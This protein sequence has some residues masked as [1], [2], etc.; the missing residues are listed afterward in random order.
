MDEKGEDE[1]VVVNAAQISGLDE[2]TLACTP[3]PVIASSAMRRRGFIQPRSKPQPKD[4][5]QDSDLVEPESCGADSN[6]ESLGLIPSH[7]LLD[8]NGS[9]LPLSSLTSSL[10]GHAASHID[11]G[12]RSAGRSCENGA[13][14]GSSIGDSSKLV[15]V[16]KSS[17]VK[18]CE[19]RLV[20]QTLFRSLSP[21]PA[22]IEEEPQEE[23]A[24]LSLQGNS[25]KGVLSRVTHTTDGIKSLTATTKEDEEADH[26]VHQVALEAEDLEELEEVCFDLDGSSSDEEPV[27]N[28]DVQ[29]HERSPSDQYF[30]P[31]G[32]LPP[33]DRLPPDGHFPPEDRFPSILYKPSKNLSYQLQADLEAAENRSASDLMDSSS[34]Y[35]QSLVFGPSLQF[36]NQHSKGLGLNPFDAQSAS[37]ADCAF[38]DEEFNT[39]MDD[40]GAKAFLDQDEQAFNKENFLNNQELSLTSARETDDTFNNMTI[41]TYMKACSEPLGLLGQESQRPD[42]GL[43]IQ[44]PPRYR[45]AAPI[46]E[47]D[48]VDGSSI[49]TSVRLSPVG[50]T[51]SNINSPTNK[52]T[53]NWS[54]PL[55]T[56]SPSVGNEYS[57]AEKLDLTA[58]NKILSHQTI[59]GQ[60]YCY[61]PDCQTNN[62]IHSLQTPP[63]KGDNT[64]SYS[65]K[66]DFQANTRT[67]SHQTGASLSDSGHSHSGKLDFQASTRT[68]P[69]QTGASLGDSGHSHSRKLDFQAST[70]TNPHQTGAS[71]GDSG[72]SYSDKQDFQAISRSHSHQTTTAI[73]E[74]GYSNDEKLKSQ[75]MNRTQSCQAETAADDSNKTLVASS[76][77][78]L[79]NMELTFS[80]LQELLERSDLS[81]S[82]MGGPDQDHGEFILAFLRQRAEEK[83]RELASSKTDSKSVLRNEKFDEGAGGDASADRS[84]Y[85]RRF[86]S[87]SIPSKLPTPSYSEKV[88]IK[89][90]DLSLLPRR[91][92]ETVQ[93]TGS[94]AVGEEAVKISHNVSSFLRDQHK[95]DEDRTLGLNDLTLSDSSVFKVPLSIASKSVRN[96]GKPSL[97]RSKIPRQV[98][99]TS[100]VVSSD[101][102]SLTPVEKSSSSSKGPTLLEKSGSLL[103]SVLS[104]TEQPAPT[105]SMNLVTNVQR[106]AHPVPDILFSAPSPSSY[107]KPPTMER[108]L[109]SESG[110]SNYKQPQ[111][112]NSSLP[113]LSIVSSHYEAQAQTLPRHDPEKQERPSTGEDEVNTAGP[114]PEHLPSLDEDR[115]LSGLTSTPDTLTEE[116]ILHTMLS[117]SET[118]IVP[119]VTPRIVADLVR[120]PETLT[121]PEPCCV[122]LSTSTHLPLT[123][124]LPKGIKCRLSVSAVAV[125]LEGGRQQ[126]I[127][128]SCCPFDFKRE[129]ALAPRTS[130]NITVIFRPKGQGT[131]MALV[132]VTAVS[133]SNSGEK[134]V[135]M[136]TLSGTAEFPTLEMWPASEQIDFGDLL[137][138]SSRCKSIRIKNVGHATV[139]LC[140]SLYRMDSSL[141][142]FSFHPEKLSADISSI[143]LSS[144]PSAAGVSNTIFSMTL[145]GKTEGQEVK[146]ETIKIYCNTQAPDKRDQN[147]YLTRAEKFEAK[148]QVSV[149]QPVEELAP[150]ASV[151]LSVNV[152]LYKLQVDTSELN[153]TAW[154]GKAGC[155]TVKL[156]NTGSI[157]MPVRVFLETSN[158]QFSVSPSGDFLVPPSESSKKSSIP[159]TVTFTPKL[160]LE[161]SKEDQKVNLMFGN[162]VC[163][164]YIPVTGRLGTTPAT[165]SSSAGNMKTVP[166]K[167]SA[168]TMHLSF[169]GVQIG[170]AGKEKLS[171]TVDHDIVV[172]ISIRQTTQ[173]FMLLDP[174]GE[175]T[176]ETVEFSAVKT[177]KHTVWVLFDPTT[178]SCYSASLIIQELNGSRYTIAL[179]GYG[180]CSSIHLEQVNLAHTETSFWLDMGRLNTGQSIFKKFVVRNQGSR[181]SF[182]KSTF[183][184]ANR[185]EFLPTKA[186]VMPSSLIL[187]PGEAKEL[188]A[189]FCPSQKEVALCQ[190][191]HALVGIIKL[192]H[193]DNI[194]REMFLRSPGRQPKQVIS[195]YDIPVPS[196]L[197]E[198]TEEELVGMNQV[199]NSYAVLKKST[200][201]INIGV[202]GEATAENGSMAALQQKVPE[203]EPTDNLEV[204]PRLSSLPHQM[205]VTPNPRPALMPL[206]QNWST[207][208]GSA[209]IVS[210]P[211]TL[212]NYTSDVTHT[213]TNSNSSLPLQWQLEP[214]APAYVKVSPQSQAV[215]RA[216]FSVFTVTPM[217]GTLQP[218]MSQKVHVKFNPKRSGSYNQVWTVQDIKN[219][220]KQVHR[221][222][223]IAHAI[224]ESPTR[225]S[226]DQEA[227][228]MTTSS[229]K[230]NELP[231][232]AADSSSHSQSGEVNKV[233]SRPSDKRSHYDSNCTASNRG[234]QEV[235]SA[236]KDVLRSRPFWSSVD[237]GCPPTD[238]EWHGLVEPRI[239]SP[240]LSSISGSSSAARRA[241][242]DST[243]SA[244]PANSTLNHSGG[245]RSDRSDRQPKG[246]HLVHSSLEFPSVVTGSSSVHKLF[247]KNQSSQDAELCVNYMPR[248]P[249]LVK[250]LKFKVSCGKITIFPV[251]FKPRHVDK[252]KDKI[253]F[254][255][256][257]TGKLLAADLVAESKES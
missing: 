159:I 203:F 79:D 65:D 41:G 213:F 251:T 56:T 211:H 89:A 70:R 88:N 110:S 131:Y 24:V 175:T 127:S 145:P 216:G 229:S 26:T 194:V 108:T 109:S 247:I 133:M 207:W 25:F 150:L 121:M 177:K 162:Q 6:N 234:Y 103:T 192:E 80:A 244:S 240:A 210:F 106:M 239:L 178:V 144:R 16:L 37:F 8:M 102:E 169:G 180:G 167:L 124:L 147:R 222:T 35:G 135:Y 231:P 78:G 233:K 199:P 166:V 120:I 114:R 94:S 48:E 98:A 12:V 115:Y 132:E 174:D 134:R 186:T 191:G 217:K 36:D 208:Q 14:T 176:R 19:G 67:D 15:T 236:E 249:F 226:W 20:P 86:D 3:V 104:K 205:G 255:D 256:L 83:R 126:Q 125:T 148:L 34:H 5:F 220:G 64:N 90:G 158:D 96:K 58:S 165:F 212:V 123:N 29:I 113:A 119:L 149:D 225:L 31:D 163:D 248:P 52:P 111:P 13:S 97:F 168:S 156:F 238:P 74:D 146:T 237:T 62:K 43:V 196:T 17:Q 63:L 33:E 195:L 22:Q 66:L 77:Q 193:G 227:Q 76:S 246:L 39:H 46:L 139:P 171:F 243:G 141:G 101:R 99:T 157:V 4:L 18:S 209:Q 172:L 198:T 116:S 136:I 69:H 45:K 82:S 232:R 93:T 228:H 202:F 224:Q 47:S 152:G 140:F 28:K 73:G 122:S 84:K 181:C 55:P 187:K 257:V 253:V 204:R 112:I 170:H 161:T 230:G 59:S 21:V 68:N 214:F 57:S 173:A 30:P 85:P 179:S 200:K 95:D 142:M 128:P 184:D 49:E 223:V 154:P 32:H 206:N 252:F 60:S 218:G 137:S 143:S 241:R 44:S 27:N 7:L 54:N 129:M 50:D 151:N 250:H 105:S 75:G 100:S 185:V 221:F 219:S 11:Q 23:E 91:P 61:M 188:L 190:A 107:P 155:A 38:G 182:I 235:N 9:E 197:R 118:S 51:G 92:Q 71:L 153:I 254:Q 42:F 1:S 189:M 53:S 72:Y 215:E 40:E 201:K 164:H 242:T 87:L 10:P 160:G 117:A 183:C 2:R 138:G 245:S 81:F 130:E